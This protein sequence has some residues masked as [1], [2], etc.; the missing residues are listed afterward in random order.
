[1][2]RYIIFII[3]TSYFLR[4][5]LAAFSIS[6]TAE[7]IM[8]FLL[9]FL[10]L[11]VNTHGADFC[12]LMRDDGFLDRGRSGRFGVKG[13][14]LAL[15]LLL[16]LLLSGALLSRINLLLLGGLATGEAAEAASGGVAFS[17][18]PLLATSGDAVAPAGESVPVEDDTAALA[19]LNLLISSA[20]FPETAF[21]SFFNASLS[22]ATVIDSKL[23]A[24]FLVSE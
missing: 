17:F 23:E 22:S 24:T 3:L 21:P 6:A 8:L 11:S 16:L 19:A 20:F 9:F 5:L 15:P 1:M 10:A 18:E 13:L 2:Y 7:A 12:R 4:T 14:L